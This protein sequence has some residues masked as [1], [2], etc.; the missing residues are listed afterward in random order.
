MH[1][2]SKPGERGAAGPGS[3]VPTGEETVSN[4]VD[5]QGLTVF[6]RH[7]QSAVAGRRATALNPAC[8]RPPSTVRVCPLVGV[9]V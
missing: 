9:A 8:D 7:F 5:G 6:V 1:A 2:I 4:L 3:Q